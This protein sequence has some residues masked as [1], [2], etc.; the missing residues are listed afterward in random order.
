MQ[1]VIIGSG[2]VASVIGC[3]LKRHNHKIIQVISRHV[4]HAKILANELQCPY[5]DL[6]SNIDTSADVYL[7]AIND[8][9]LFSLKDH[10][11]IGNKLVLHTAGSVSKD[12]LKEISINYGVLYP[13]QSLRKEMLYKN[14]IPFLIDGN[15][16]ENIG[17]ISDFAKTI[18]TKVTQASDEERIKLHVAAVVV[19]N[20]SNHLFAL[21]EEFCK[22]ENIDFKL[23]EPLIFETANR[24]SIYSPN[25]VQTGPAIRN[26]VFTLD[27][28]IQLLQNHPR[29]KYM[30]LKLTESIMKG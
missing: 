13:L 10:F 25:E 24:L 5:T 19:S 29:L 16:Q 23:L 2:N 17:I 6:Y 3:L 8:E 9:A 22:K 12:V 30:Y 21:A 7:V 27:K 1:V 18:S 4:N 26:D 15:S 28:H 14:E 20:F 11:H